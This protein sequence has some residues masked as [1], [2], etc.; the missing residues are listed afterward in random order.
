MKKISIIL[1]ILIFT[2]VAI[3]IAKDLIIKTSI[4][5]IVSLA[6]GLRMDIGTLRVSVTK[7]YIDI[8]D[9]VIFNPPHF[10][11]KV[12]LKAPEVYI[13]YDLPAILKKKV[14][15]NEV[16]IDLRELTIVK[17]RANKTNL[18]YVKDLKPKQGK[19]AEEASGEQGR[20][21]QIDNLRLKI[22]KVIYKDY[23][24]GEKPQVSEYKINLDSSYKNVKNTKE[25]MRII[26]SK[27][28]INTAIGTISGVG[29]FGED[30]ASDTLEGGKDVLKKT[31]GEIKDILK[32]PFKDKE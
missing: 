26:I 27:A 17:N 22:G 18:D 3:S 28:V 30:V 10:N 6:T 4:E 31:V 11:D 5:G 32:N 25:I 20:R 19:A 1:L 15:L 7:T 21:L 13:D 12:M 8:K 23:S 29:K 2:V 9:M 14:H 24:A 16:R